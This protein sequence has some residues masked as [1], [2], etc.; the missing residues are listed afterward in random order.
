M[1]MFNTETEKTVM[2]KPGHEGCSVYSGQVDPTGKYVAT[3]GSDGF[4]NIYK[5]S[6]D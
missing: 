6:D 5:F 3:T 1:S 2:C 4:I